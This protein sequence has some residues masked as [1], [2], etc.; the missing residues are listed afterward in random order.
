ME[1][2]EAGTSRRAWQQQRCR[3]GEGPGGEDKEEGVATTAA[4]RRE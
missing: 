1:G 2:L 4:S 3:Q